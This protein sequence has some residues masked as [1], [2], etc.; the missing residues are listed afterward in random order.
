MSQNDFSE[1]DAALERFHRGCGQTLIDD[2]EILYACGTPG[3]DPCDDC[4][5]TYLFTIGYF[6]DDGSD[7]A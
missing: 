6:D 4:L 1:G 7:A 2:N 5:Q 3:V